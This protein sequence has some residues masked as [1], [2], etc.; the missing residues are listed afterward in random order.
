MKDKGK[1]QKQPTKKLTQL[2]RRITELEKKDTARRRTEQDVQ[3][4][5]TRYRRLFES[6]QDGILI[7]E[8]ETGKIIDVNPFM[9]E[10]LGY[11]RG[12]FLGKQ[13]WE[14]GLFKDI[15][16]NKIAF[17]RLQKEKYIRY[18]HLPLSTKDGKPRDVEFVSNVYLANGN[19]VIQCNIRD[20][21]ERKR[22]ERELVNIGTHDALTSLPNR[23]L[24]DDRLKIALAHAMRSQKKIAVMLLDLDRFKEVN[25]TLGHDV[26]DK[27]LQAVGDRLTKLLRKMDTI[28]RLGGDEFLL[29]LPQIGHEKYAVTIAQKIIVAFHKPFVVDAH[30]IVITVSIGVVIAPDDGDDTDILVKSADIAMYYAKGLGRDNYQLY[31]SVIAGKDR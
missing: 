9:I 12:E 23:V 13:L 21:T 30:E 20:I 24:F 19:A 2:R 28:A 17:E 5:E 31:A 16:A 10:I 15:A 25:D 6:A 11:A 26:G 18:E 3:A 4:S 27:L 29:L 1:T 7:L 8:A 22:Q 14:I